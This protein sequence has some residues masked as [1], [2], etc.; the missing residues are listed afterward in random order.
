MLDVNVIARRTKR[1]TPD[2]IR[3]LRESTGLSQRA[4]A[5]VA[6]VAKETVCRWESGT[7]AITLAHERFL[8]LFVAAGA[9]SW[10]LDAGS[11]P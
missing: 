1:L 7:Q 6:G 5:D 2:L 4:Y 3:A 10:V 9:P 11:K 8:R